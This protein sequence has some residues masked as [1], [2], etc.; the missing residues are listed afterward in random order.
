MVRRLELPTMRKDAGVGRRV[1]RRGRKRGNQPGAFL[2]AAR[3]PHPPDGLQLARLL[4]RCARQRVARAWSKSSTSPSARRRTT[5]AGMDRCS[6]EVAQPAKPQ[7]LRGDVVG[8]RGLRRGTPEASNFR[9][10]RQCDAGGW[11][12]HGSWF[13]PTNAAACQR[14]GRCRHRCSG[15][16]GKFNGGSTQRRTRGCLTRALTD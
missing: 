11:T 4:C 8:A 7:R 5:R 14:R 10:S 1:P 3:S 15:S 13:C 6:A 9:G 12:G 16:V 2:P